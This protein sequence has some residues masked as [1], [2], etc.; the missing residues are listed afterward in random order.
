MVAVAVPTDF[1][2]GVGRREE[3][4]TFAQDRS[5]V[6]VWGT[7]RTVLFLSSV[8]D[9]NL[10]GFVVILG[11]FGSLGHPPRRDG[12]LTLRGDEFAMIVT[13]AEVGLADRH[14]AYPAIAK[15]DTV[16]S[17]CIVGAEQM[18][19]VLGRVVDVEVS[20]LQV[21]D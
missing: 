5:G 1:D 17:A 8:L 16:R 19:A 11:G 2:L 7:A 20:R 9:G 10:S 12:V 3:A 15:F 21:K 14:L 13:D 6:I 18:F 4:L